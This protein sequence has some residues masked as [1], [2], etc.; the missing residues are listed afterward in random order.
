MKTGMLIT[1]NLLIVAL[2]QETTYGP[3]LSTSPFK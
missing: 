3:V 1:H 2:K